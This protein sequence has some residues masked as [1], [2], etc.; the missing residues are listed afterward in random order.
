MASTLEFRYTGGASNSNPDASLGG[1]SST[2]LI[3][4][5]ALNNLFDDVTPAEALA[6]S[7]EYRALDVYNNGD[8]AAVGVDLFMNAETTSTD[9]QL[10]FGL[11]A[12]PTNSTTSIVDETT[13]PVGVSFA[14]YTSAS[15][16]SL[17][18]FAAGAYVRVWI[19]RTVTAGAANLANDQGTIRVEYA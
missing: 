8:A 11:E 12:V 1:V 19:K 15:K 7:T 17:P 18:D 6:G 4:S 10:D 5:T 3:S 9:T 2:A 14:H 16:L 13:A